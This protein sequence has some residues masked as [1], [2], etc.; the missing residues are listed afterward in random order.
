MDPK[1]R[2]LCRILILILTLV[3]FLAACQPLGTAIREPKA[4]AGSFGRPFQ[5]T[6]PVQPSLLY[7]AWKTR[8]FAS[9]I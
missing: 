2:K 4:Q 5:S 3:G 8:V 9:T 1:N 6:S 7:L